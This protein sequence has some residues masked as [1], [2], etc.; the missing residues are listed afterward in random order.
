MNMKRFSTV[1]DLNVQKGGF[2]DGKLE[3]HGWQHKLSKT[4]SVT[5]EIMRKNVRNAS[6]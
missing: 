6:L 1:S 3:L 4:G 2:Y 5:L